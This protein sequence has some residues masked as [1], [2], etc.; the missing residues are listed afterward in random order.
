MDDRTLQRIRWKIFKTGRVTQ[1]PS[2]SNTSTTFRGGFPS[3]IYGMCESL[4]AQTRLMKF[5]A[6]FPANIVA[7]ASLFAHFATCKIER[8]FRK[9]ELLNR[10][11]Y[12]FVNFRCDFFSHTSLLRVYSWCIEMVSDGNENLF[13]H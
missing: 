1:D 4:Q 5:S 7:N 10:T 12:I 13:N 2:S 11:Y 8:E 9:R 6:N 3:E